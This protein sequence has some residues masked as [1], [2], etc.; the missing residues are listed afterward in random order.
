MGQIRRLR[1]LGPRDSSSLPFAFAVAPSRPNVPRRFELNDKAEEWRWVG[2]D[3]VE[4]PVAEGELIAELSS[5]SLPNYTLVWKKGW[6]EG[7]AAREGGCLG[8]WRARRAAARAGSLPGGKAAPPV[9]PGNRRGAAPPPA[10][11][12]Y[13]YP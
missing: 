9:R 11:P 7:V 6:V 4:K 1:E 8:G 5:E 12:L 2:E 3:G 10:P 13:R